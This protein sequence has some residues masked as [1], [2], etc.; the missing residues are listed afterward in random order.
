MQSTARDFWKMVYDSKCGV[1]VSTGG[2]WRGEETSCVGVC[3]YN[4]VCLS[5]G[6]VLPVLAQ[7][8]HTHLWRVHSGDTGGEDVQSILFEVFWSTQCQGKSLLFSNNQTMYTL[9]EW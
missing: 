6:G 3:R 8:W 5:T 9:L 1:I 2:G 7:Q 4:C